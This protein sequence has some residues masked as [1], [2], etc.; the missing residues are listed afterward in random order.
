MR[1]EKAS[2]V[3][4]RK[5]TVTRIIKLAL[6][7]M[8]GLIVLAVLLVPV[9]V[10]SEKGRRLIL[11]K[12]N[13]AI[14]GKADFAD[15]SMGWLKGIKVANL[16]FNDAAGE[17][18][19][20]VEQVS[21]KPAYGSILTGK[22]SLGR[23]VI[24]KP[25]IEVNLRDR[26]R[27]VTRRTGEQT[28]VSGATAPVVLPI[29]TIDLVLN[30]GIVKVTDPKS[31][32]VELSQINSRVNLQP[33]PGQ[34][35]F[36]LSMVVARAD[37]VS[38]IKAAGHVTTKPKDGWSLKGTSG[39]LK[40]EVKDLDLESL[41]PIF[42]LVGVEVEAKGVVNGTAK[43]QIKDG[44]FEN[45]TA[46]IK[47]TNLDVT[48]A[49]LKGDRL[50]TSALDV[51][52]KLSQGEETITVDALTVES[53]WATV[54]ATG[55]VPTGF[56]SA[57][58][59]LEVDSGYDLKGDFNCDLAAVA[60]RMPRTLGLKEGTQVTAGRLTGN[61]ETVTSAGRKRA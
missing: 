20:K 16:S 39:D 55:T 14:A 56:K 12:I 50:Q 1:V 23:T 6:P 8:L 57:G 25:R 21:T 18:S 53:D 37:K 42:A 60:A 47:A 43:G 22:L 24:D 9:F 44:R 34:S 31:G 30:D 35:D 36:D 15:L 40:I 27:T 11:A 52:A 7:L 3:K 19:V 5:R 2:N 58:D 10:S 46:G 26:E 48:A 17:I 41:G 49:Q 45:L 33:P 38:Q 59:F 54:T 29:K 51:T 4:P 61:V 13:G 28:P 32:T